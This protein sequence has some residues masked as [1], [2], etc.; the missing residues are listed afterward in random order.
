MPFPWPAARNTCCDVGNEI[1]RWEVEPLKRSRRG[2]DERLLMAAPF[3]RLLNAAV[4]RRS[5][6]SPLRRAVVTRTVRIGIAALNRGDYELISRIAHPEIELQMLPDEPHNR[7]AGLDPVYRGP[8]SYVRSLRIWK[9]PFGEHEFEV[10]E[11]FDSGGARFAA[12]MPQ[13]ARGLGS[14]AEVRQQSFYVWELE[15]GALRRQWILRT[16]AAMF[17]LLA[18]QA[19][20]G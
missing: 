12:R 15:D 4:L 2:L 20:A 10:R 1:A 16:E 9:E 19:S 13:V 8:D 3:R 14:G 6:G 17:E 5:P 18:V 11:I 7:P